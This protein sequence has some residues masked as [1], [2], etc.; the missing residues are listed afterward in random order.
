MLRHRN[1]REIGGAAADVDHQDQVAHLDPLAPVR[2]A[3]DP[4]VEGR[5]R[6]FQQGQVLIAGLLRGLQRQFARHRIK[7]SRHRHQHLLLGKRRIGH[8]MIPGFAQVFEVAAAG[9]NRRNLLDPLRRAERHQ[10]RGAVDAGI[11]EPRLGRRNQ[12]AGIFGAPFLRERAD[13]EVAAGVPRQSQRSRGKVGRAR[14]IQKRR[15]QV[16]LANFR[17]IGELR[18][19]H[20]LHVGRSERVGI[21]ANLG[22][23]EG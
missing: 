9:R 23:R 5:L 22:V 7:G 12:P 16:F 13:G 21:L 3:F 14:Q 19:G 20:H 1:Q 11:R 2:V 8:A 10:G 17:G 15:Q 4:R 18:D 6:L